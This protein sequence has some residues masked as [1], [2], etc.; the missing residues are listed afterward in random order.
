MIQGNMDRILCWIEAN[1]KE[2]KRKNI[3]SDKYTLQGIDNTICA[4]NNFIE[5]NVKKCDNNLDKATDKNALLEF[6]NSYTNYVEYF[7]FI[8]R[9]FSENEILIREEMRK[10]V[11][12]INDLIKEAYEAHEIAIS[13]NY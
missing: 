7:Y 13:G 8:N 11:N 6:I 5:N 10:L 4:L 3:K 12:I 1:I 9:E 2:Y